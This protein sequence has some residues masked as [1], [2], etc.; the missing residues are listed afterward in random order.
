MTCK[1]DVDNWMS[2]LPTSSNIKYNMESGGPSR[3]GK[4]VP[5]TRWYIIMPVQTKKADQKK[6]K[7]KKKK[8]EAAKKKYKAKNSYKGKL[9]Q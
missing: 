5:F 2:K 7:K 6:R 4:R 8:Q 9:I 3:T 1:N